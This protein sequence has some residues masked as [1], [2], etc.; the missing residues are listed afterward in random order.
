MKDK[1]GTVEIL[2]EGKPDPGTLHALALGLLRQLNIFGP[3]KQPPTEK[4]DAVLSTHNL[5]KMGDRYGPE[6]KKREVKK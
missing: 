6:I 3:G 4:R 5:Q 1:P 2:G